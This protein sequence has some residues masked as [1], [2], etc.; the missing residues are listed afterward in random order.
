MSRIIKICFIYFFIHFLISCAAVESQNL[1][2][3]N[4][5]KRMS[6]L[7]S[8]TDLQLCNAYNHRLIQPKTE[9]QL[10]QLLREREIYTCTSKGQI[11]KI[12]PQS[13]PLESTPLKALPT[14]E[15]G[16]SYAKSKSFQNNASVSKQSQKPQAKRYDN[17][18]LFKNLTS[19]DISVSNLVPGV[20]TR[21]DFHAAAIN[22]LNH[23]F[24]NFD[25]WGVKLACRGYFVEELL[26]KVFCVTG[27][28]YTTMSNL[29]VHARFKRILMKEY[30]K[31][32]SN[33]MLKDYSPE[34]GEYSTEKIVWLDKIGNVIVLSSQQQPQN[35]LFVLST[36]DN[37]DD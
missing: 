16:N 5:D 25:L 11:R 23:E 9:K 27:G 15:S 17:N 2:D 19:K 1:E 3:M 26:V 33:N 7:R 29:D 37:I 32:F 4:E 24:A 20:S 30:G 6:L 12:S 31:P 18:P 34:V 8:K 21:K 22:S 14:P 35:G 13:G 36:I 10:E 28:E